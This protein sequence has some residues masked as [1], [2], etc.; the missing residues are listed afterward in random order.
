[1]SSEQGAVP[2]GYITRAVSVSLALPV[3]MIALGGL[4]RVVLPAWLSSVLD[5]SALAGLGFVAYLVGA[6]ILHRACRPRKA[7][8]VVVLIAYDMGMPL[9]VLG[10]V[11]LVEAARGGR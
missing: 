1:M 8:W 2:N 4:A 7:R 10:L 5:F 9:A 3:V 11:A 6:W